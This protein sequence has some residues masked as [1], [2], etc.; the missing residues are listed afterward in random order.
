MRRYGESAEDAAGDKPKGTYL[1][2]LDDVR[3]FSRNKIDVAKRELE[4]NFVFWTMDRKRQDCC[5]STDLILQTE[6]YRSMLC[7]EGD[8]IPG[9]RLEAFMSC[10]IM[11][12]VSSLRIFQEKEKLKSLLTG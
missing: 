10:G 3:H 8:T 9:D 5:T 2:V 6:L 7:E 11:S 12:R 1:Q 4:L